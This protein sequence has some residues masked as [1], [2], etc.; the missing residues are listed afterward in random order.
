MF[1]VDPMGALKEADMW[2]RTRSMGGRGFFPHEPK[3]Q[4]D[5]ITPGKSVRH[6]CYD[7]TVERGSEMCARALKGP[8][9]IL[10]F[11][12]GNDR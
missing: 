4:I 2:D 9:A 12:G 5:E 7:R 8:S 3:G 10:K 1:A 6:R 11:V